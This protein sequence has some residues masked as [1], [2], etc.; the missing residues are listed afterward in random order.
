MAMDADTGEVIWERRF[1][2]AMSDAPPHR[3]AWASPVVDRDSGNVYAFGVD[4]T[5]TALSPAGEVLWQR[6]LAEQFGYVSTHGGR[7]V[8]PVIAGGSVIVSG[9]TSGWGDLSIGRHR[10][11]AFDLETG[12]TVWVTTLP[13]APFD[14]TY[15]PPY[16]TEVD[17]RRVLITGAG[18]GAV[19]ALVANTGER[20]WRYPMSQRGI[21]NG[22]VVR[23]DTAIVSHGEENVDSNEMGYIAA[24]DIGGAGEL[25][26]EAVRWERTGFLG[27]YPSPVLDDERIYHI[28]NGSN[29]TAFDF[30]TG[31]R[32]WQRNLGT[33][34]KASPVLADGK[35]WVGAVNGGFYVIRPTAT[36]AEILDRVQ[37][38]TEDHE[39][40]I[41]ASVAVARDTVYLVTEEA[42]YAIGHGDAPA[43]DGTDVGSGDRVTST[44]GSAAT[45]GAGSTASATV[46]S[47]ASHGT[48]GVTVTAPG[49]S[50][51]AA[52]AAGYRDPAAHLQVLPAELVAT[53]G[54]PI[55]LRARGFDRLG[56]A[57]G[58]VGD[59]AEWSTEGL[60]GSFTDPGAFVADPEAGAQGGKVTAAIRELVG[61]SRI[62]AI[63]RL[64][65]RLDF[66]SVEGVPGH[67]VG[68]GGR[69][70]LRTLDAGTEDADRVLV[71]RVASGPLRRARVYMGSSDTSNYS[72]QVD[73]RSAMESRRM[74][75]VGVIAQRYALKLFGSHQ[76][77]ELMSWQ[78]ET[79]RTVSRRFRWEPDRWYR[80]LLRVENLGDGRVRTRGKVWAADEPEPD[81]WTIERV[82][83]RGNTRGSPGIFADAHA[84]VILDD[85]RVT[86]NR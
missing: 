21:Q 3:I 13:D 36:G 26:E 39:V 29:L 8:S 72:V 75:D 22:V 20:L 80:I 25:G 53:P 2:V 37:F 60:A 18:D 62:R 63:P 32:L 50:S 33:I 65:W 19:H 73:A 9:L 47:P 43:E 64:P 85:L 79:E 83:P 31:E 70:E 40:S 10:F 82:D 84:E 76:K 15:S 42:I 58:S 5:L 86:P 69:F 52:G 4:G 23:G 11:M 48:I 55:R 51:S 34:Q 24:I 49:E 81:E 77:L 38:G 56:E 17:G 27:G 71:K 16:L 67:W 6:Y 44:D 14:T 1:N 28:D 7:T 78:P 66:E 35:L 45:D 59:R 30:D 57:T 54:V 41:R 46:S 74:G 61:V 12:R 68:A